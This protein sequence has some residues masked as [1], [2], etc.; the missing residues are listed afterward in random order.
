MADGWR[1]FRKCFRFFLLEGHGGVDWL[2]TG[3][4]FANLFDLFYGSGMAE[5]IR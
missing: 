2:K 4:R 3:A 5:L 1:T